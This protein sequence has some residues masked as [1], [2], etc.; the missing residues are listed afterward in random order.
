M[1]QNN[2]PENLISPD[3]EMQLK[4]TDNTITIP[5]TEID[6]EEIMAVIRENIRR[7]QS[8]GEFPKNKDSKIA[9]KN[10][11][12]NIWE[13]Y[14]RDLSY[15]N[16]NCDIR[17][18]SYHIS[19]HHPYI[20]RILVK[21]RQLV[22][23]EIRRYVDPMI[24]RQFEFNE[25]AVRLFADIFSRDEELL[26]KISQQREELSKNRLCLEELSHRISQ[27][28]GALSNKLAQEL[29]RTETD[30][31]KSVDSIIRDAFSLIDKDH[32]LQTGL[33]HIL[34]ERLQVL[35]SQIKTP[36]QKENVNYFLFEERFRGSRE[37]I[38]KR[39][40]AFF[41][42][43]ENSS[44]VIDIGCGRGE[45]LEI[46]R[47][48][49]IEGIGIDI[50]LDMIA[51]CRSHQLNVEQIDA[52]EYLEKLEDNSLEGIFIDQVVEHLEPD[53]LVRLL[54]LSHK[55][56]KS[57]YY[58]VVETVNPLT[59]VSYVN[60][61]I[62]LTHKRLVHPETLQ[63]LMSVAGFGETEKKFFSPVS[64]E[65]KLKKIPVISETD[66][67]QKN[68]DV[69]NHNIEILNTILFG[70]QDYAVIGKK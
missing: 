68:V 16:S 50:D 62:D 29:E 57:G 17:N 39:Q 15:I 41:P 38:K 24:S 65:G 54:A 22:H 13:T 48:H 58:L 19:T 14:Q 67:N 36:I 28:D 34:E 32:R 46:L 51:F 49:G 33:T 8:S 21:G 61:L 4:M 56:L 53:Y 64:D 31:K 44:R 55:K 27:Q 23:G 11:T 6:V 10:Q 40:L 12:D 5:N 37:E 20:G 45:F 43:F 7:R 60:F 69:Y 2:V 63:F 52:I 42:Y 1:L 47:D 9:S 3:R 59:F 66:C 35:Q 70:A 30:I 18:S 25:G 26:N